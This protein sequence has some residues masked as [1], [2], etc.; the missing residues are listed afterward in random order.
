MCGDSPSTT[1]TV[2][3]AARIPFGDTTTADSC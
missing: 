1:H 2:A 3:D